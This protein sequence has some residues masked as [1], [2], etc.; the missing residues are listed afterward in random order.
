MVQVSLSHRMHPDLCLTAKY[1]IVWL[2]FLGEAPGPL[3]GDYEHC[4]G[5]RP[6]VSGWPGDQK[7]AGD[8]HQTE[9]ARLQPERP[10]V[11]SRG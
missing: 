6:H 1:G 4:L 7:G 2:P 3:V 9:M 5:P 10:V 11:A 8:G